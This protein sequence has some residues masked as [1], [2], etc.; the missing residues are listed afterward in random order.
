MRSVAVL[1]LLLVCAAAFGAEE[2]KP[3]PQKKDTVFVAG[4]LTGT[5]GAP[6]LV[7]FS[8]VTVPA[9]AP[10]EVAFKPKAERLYVQ[11]EARGATF[12]LCEGWEAWIYRTSK[13]CSEAK[14]LTFQKKDGCYS[15]VLE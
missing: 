9:C 8:T 2:P 10:T 4:E 5:F 13:A 12:K 6:P 15:P 3:W 14:P 1:A 11:D 7:Q